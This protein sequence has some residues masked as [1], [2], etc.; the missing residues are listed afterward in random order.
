MRK[1]FSFALSEPYGPFLYIWLYQIEV[2]IE[3]FKRMMSLVKT[4]NEKVDE[5]YWIEVPRGKIDQTW[6]KMKGVLII[7]LKL[8]SNFPMYPWILLRFTI[9]LLRLVE[10]E[11]HKLSAAKQ[12]LP[13]DFEMKKEIINY[14]LK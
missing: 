3:Y 6:G 2:E 9:D 5:K 10:F 1:N 13:A 12:K 14:V 7:P 4:E 11:C 8:K